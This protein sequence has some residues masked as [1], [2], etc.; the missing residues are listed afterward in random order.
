MKSY[1]RE[2]QRRIDRQIAEVERLLK[3]RRLARIR[4][5]VKKNLAKKD[6]L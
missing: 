6:G 3:L 2:E 4:E 1:T 5:Q